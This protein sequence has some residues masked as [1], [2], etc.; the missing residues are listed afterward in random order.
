MNNLPHSAPVFVFIE[1]I[2]CYSIIYKSAYIYGLTREDMDVLKTT[3]RYPIVGS[4]GYKCCEICGKR[5]VYAT[6]IR[7]V[8]AKMLCDHCRETYESIDYERETS[9]FI[10]GSWMGIPK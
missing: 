1:R 7:F 3:N 2:Q 4:D 5:G 8:V 6:I 10:P 9:L